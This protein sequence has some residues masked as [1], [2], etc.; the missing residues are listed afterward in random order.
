MTDQ[1]TIAVTGLPAPQGSK[2][3]FYNPKL[4]RVQMV[5]SSKKVKPWRQDV[6]AAALNA[7]AETGWA[8]PSVAVEVAIAFHMPRPR[9]HFGTGRNAH[10]L[11]PGAPVYVDKKPD[12]DKLVRST[13]DALTSADVLRDDAQVGRL[14]IDELYANGPTGAQITIR[15]LTAVAAAVPS[16]EHPAATAPATVQEALL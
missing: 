9:Y 1:L 3:G 10:Q 12:I 8:P 2:S 14:V 4:G 15:P 5:E 13:L 16:P 7:K 6:T 11:K